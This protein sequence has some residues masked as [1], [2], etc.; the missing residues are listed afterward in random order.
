MG[1]VETGPVQF[2]DDRPGV[3]IC[4]DNAMHYAQMLQLAA[5]R[6]MEHGD[7]GLAGPLIS[8][9]GLLLS[10]HVDV[11]DPSLMLPGVED[12]GSK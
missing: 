1:R 10:S 8:F 11:G 3:F 7:N 2:G 4:G 5:K 12:G 9:S 6:L